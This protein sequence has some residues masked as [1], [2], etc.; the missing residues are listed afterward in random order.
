MLS[1]LCLLTISPLDMDTD[2][3]QSSH[4]LWGWETFFEEVCAFVREASRQFG[5]CTEDYDHYAVERL[6]LCV[7]NTSRL[8]ENLVSHTSE[9]L[10]QNRVVNTYE[11]ELQELIE[12]LRSLSQEWQNYFD[13]RERVTEPASFRVSV[14]SRWSRGRPWFQISREQLEY[15]R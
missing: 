15:L 7:R 1:H 12:C 14:D 5:N 13:V 10:L 11:R 3:Q 8:R 6:Q 2:G 4:E 9:I